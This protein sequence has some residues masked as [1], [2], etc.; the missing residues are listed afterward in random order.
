VAIF[1]GQ[2]VWMTKTVTIYDDTVEVRDG[3]TVSSVAIDH[4]AGVDY[5]RAFPKYNQ[6][7]LSLISLRDGGGRR[8][9]SAVMS[10]EQVL[11]AVR[12]LQKIIATQSRE[13]VVRKEPYPYL[14]AL[15]VLGVLVLPAVA[16]VMRGASVG[17]LIVMLILASILSLIEVVIQLRHQPGPS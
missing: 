8:I 14:P 10:Y 13:L 17:V 6:Y 4:L 16:A 3:R 5:G 15:A 12:L 2:P 9:A 11:E 1:A 7:R